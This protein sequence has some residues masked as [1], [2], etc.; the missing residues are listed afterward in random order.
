VERPYGGI[1]DGTFELRDAPAGKRRVVAIPEGEEFAPSDV[2]AVEIPGEGVKIVVPRCIE[3]AVLLEG[4]NE[5]PYFATWRGAAADGTP[6]W[7]SATSG[8]GGRF[9]LRL[10][11]TGPGTLYVRSSHDDRYALVQALY[12]EGPSPRSVS[13]R[14][15]LSVSGSVEGLEPG[16][17][18]GSRILLKGPDVE[19]A[20]PLSADATFVVRGL[21]VGAYEVTVE[22]PAT[23]SF[24]TNTPPQ[25]V[26]AG[27]KDVVIRDAIRRVQK[28]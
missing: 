3:F 9:A 27:S 28:R 18:A 20:V 2:V 4:A 25:I 15:G 23:F 1:R 19:T 11:P 24:A 22:V 13:L 10:P 14:T 5:K 6:I 8:A 21:P 26:Q 16:E 12:V 7:R 17:A